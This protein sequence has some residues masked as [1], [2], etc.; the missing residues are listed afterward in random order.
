MMPDQDNTNSV[1]VNPTMIY[2][3]TEH[4][5]PNFKGNLRL[6]EVNEDPGPDLNVFLTLLEN[7][8]KQENIQDLKVKREKLIACLDHHHGDALQIVINNTRLEEAKD[9]ATYE[10]IFRSLFQDNNQKDV[11]GL[12]SKLI[13]LVRDKTESMASFEARVSQHLKEVRRAAEARGWNNFSTTLNFIAEVLLLG[14][15]NERLRQVGLNID[16]PQTSLNMVM[17]LIEEKGKKINVEVTGPS[18]HQKLLMKNKVD[19]DPEIAAIEKRN[20][21]HCNSS[22]HLRRNCPQLKNTKEERRDFS[23]ERSKAPRSTKK[24]TYEDERNRRPY[25]YGNSSYRR[26]ESPYRDSRNRHQYTSGSRPSRSRD[27]NDYRRYSERRSSS[28]ERTFDQRYRFPPD[29][30]RNRSQSPR[31]SYNHYGR[32]HSRD[33]HRSLTR[34]PSPFSRW[35]PARGDRNVSAIDRSPNDSYGHYYVSFVNQTDEGDEDT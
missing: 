3:E 18:L 22:T 23:Y 25:Q 10:R 7:K 27:N 26:Q 34:S 31:R 30:Y 14:E 6:S 20:C 29:T 13:Y 2:V 19:K 21:H 33:S 24:V 15:C 4:Q 35:S 9:W 8:F 28:R 1:P 32:S 5:I 12:T 16:Q 17:D 11:H